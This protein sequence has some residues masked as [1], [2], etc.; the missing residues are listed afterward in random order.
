M[1]K[2]ERLDRIEK[3][4]L[5]EAIIRAV[6]KEPDR[7]RRFVLVKLKLIDTVQQQ[8]QSDIINPSCPFD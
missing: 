1:E 2:S 5:T 3:K 8:Q 6:K 7:K 4:V